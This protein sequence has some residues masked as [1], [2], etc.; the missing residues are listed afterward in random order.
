MKLRLISQEIK[1]Y[2]QIL[3]LKYNPQSLSKEIILKL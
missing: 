2:L 3:E 1:T